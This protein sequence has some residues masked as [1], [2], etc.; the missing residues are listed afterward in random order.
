MQN[1]LNSTYIFIKSN[2]N[3][4]YVREALSLTLLV[5]SQQ[6][7]EITLDCIIENIL[8]VSFNNK[9]YD[10]F[11]H[12]VL[13]YFKYKKEFKIFKIPKRLI[14]DSHLIKCF[15]KRYV[16]IIDISNLRLIYD[17]VN[18]KNCYKIKDLKK[19]F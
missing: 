2:K 17:S 1:F 12:F 4:A 6:I 9:D 16:G 14:T 13:K 10:C 15:G 19:I 11:N 7:I 3:D 8:D 18:L 5:Q